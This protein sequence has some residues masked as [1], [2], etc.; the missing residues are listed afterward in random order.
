MAQL[1][2]EICCP[3]GQQ[4]PKSRHQVL[5]LKHKKTRSKNGDSGLR[6]RIKNHMCYSVNTEEIRNYKV[7]MEN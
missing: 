7:E 2:E 1:F 6:Q 4:N 3:K 5:D